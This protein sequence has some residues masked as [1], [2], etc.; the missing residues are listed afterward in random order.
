MNYE[1]PELLERLAGEYVLGTLRGAARRRFA[2]LCAASPAARAPVIRWED[3]LSALS[4]SLEPVTPSARVWAGVQRQLSGAEGAPARR[5]P[6]R[7]R[8]LAI[9]AAVVAVALL[10]GLFVHEQRARL[11]TLA[12]LGPD[13]AHTQWRIERTRELTAL[14]IS[15]VG[16][17]E[18]GPAKAYE[19]WA[20][21]RGGQPV[22]LG[23]LPVRGTLE[24]PLSRAQSAALLAADKVA[25]SLE[26][27]GGSPSGAPTGPI[28]IVTPVRVS[29]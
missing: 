16:R 23:L 3:E 6:G 24:R 1:R 28:V 8:R 11:E 21:P 10:I 13:A 9:A 29:G 27:A 25:V 5:V 2:R 15:A 22:S 18:P 7:V 20:L 14:T 12:L 26:P 4:G 19:L 17:I